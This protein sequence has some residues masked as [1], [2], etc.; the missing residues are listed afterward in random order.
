[1]KFIWGGVE[2]W[3]GNCQRIFKRLILFIKGHNEICHF[4]IHT[5]LSMKSSIFL[6][7]LYLSC[8]KTLL[9]IFL[10]K[11]LQRQV[12][13][14]SIFL[15]LRLIRGG[16]VFHGY[17]AKSELDAQNL[18]HEIFCFQNARHKFTSAISSSQ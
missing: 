11:K 1:M 12:R 17:R 16:N 10:R 18:S 6:V 13:T 7:K 3:V 15:N 2:E 5:E 4:L 8:L 14:I 9:H